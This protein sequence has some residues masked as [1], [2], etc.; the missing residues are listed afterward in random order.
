M[1]LALALNMDKDLSEIKADVKTLIEI[2]KLTRHEQENKNKVLFEFMNESNKTLSQVQEALV[3]NKDYSKSI[4]H[5]LKIHKE[6]HFSW[7]KISGVGVAVVSGLAAL[8]DR[9]MGWNR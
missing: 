5:D 2:S 3:N 8:A 4:S 7:L 1:E 6:N 9:I